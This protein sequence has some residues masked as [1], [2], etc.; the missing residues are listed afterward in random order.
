[1]FSYNKSVTSYIVENDVVNEFTDFILNIGLTENFADGNLI[2]E[3][4]IL[5]NL[6]VQ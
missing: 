2:Y 4:R 5:E 6:S 1:M 3:L